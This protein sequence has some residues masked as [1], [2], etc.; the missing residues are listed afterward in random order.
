M[1]HGQLLFC[2][3]IWRH[4]VNALGFLRSLNICLTNKEKLLAVTVSSNI[5]CRPVHLW[6][7]MSGDKWP[8]VA[9]PPTPTWT[10]GSAATTE[11]ISELFQINVCV[12][13]W[14][15]WRCEACPC[16]GGGGGHLA[17]GG[18]CAGGRHNHWAVRGRVEVTHRG[19]VL[20]HRPTATELVM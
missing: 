11:I 17:G 13:G 14:C 5:A 9:P 20:L 10:L 8:R 15:W 1:D 12:C 3:W 16:G 19:P 18:G 7:M 4:L 6:V 2:R